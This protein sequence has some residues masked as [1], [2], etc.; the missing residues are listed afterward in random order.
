MKLKE[1]LKG[2]LTEKERALLRGFHVIGDI[3]LIEIPPVLDKKKK[4]IAQTLRKLLPY[5]KVVAK[6]Q[7]G[8]KGIFRKQNLQILAGENRKITIHKEFGLDFAMDVEKCFFSPKLSTER[9]RIVKQVK[10][11]ENILVMFSGVAP[12]VLMLAKHSKANRIYG[13]EK[14]PVAHKY[15]VENVMRNKLGHKVILIKGDANKPPKGMKFDRVLMPWPMNADSFLPAAIRTTKKGGI[16]HYYDFMPENDHKEARQIVLAAC[17][18]A[19]RKCKILRT[20]ECGQTAMRTYRV[21]VD[22]KLL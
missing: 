22:F 21:C 10:K 8:H 18:T 15:A 14:N 9:M 16:I 6:K 19:K 20:V 5:I 11:G 1:A 3:A 2:K 13:I 17:E 4:V 12:Y 7:G